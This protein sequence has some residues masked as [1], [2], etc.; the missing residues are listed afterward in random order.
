[1][2][3]NQQETDKNSEVSKLSEQEKA[4]EARKSLRVP[5]S[6]EAYN[7]EYNPATAEK[8][9]TL[10]TRLQT[11]TERVQRNQSAQITLEQIDAIATELNLE[12]RYVR[13]AMLAT[14]AAKTAEQT[15]AK[16]SPVSTQENFAEVVPM[17][18]YVKKITINWWLIAWITLPF[19]ILF[20]YNISNGGYFS[21]ALFIYITQGI[22]FT[23]WSFLEKIATKRKN[24][25]IPTK[26][27]RTAKVSSWQ[28]AKLFTVLWWSIGW[29]IPFI[30]MGLV[31][32]QMTMGHSN[33]SAIV[34]MGQ[35]NNPVPSIIGFSL[36]FIH[37]T[38]GALLT[39]WA[40]NL[41]KK[42]SVK[43]TPPASTPISPVS[44]NNFSRQELL[45]QLFALQKSLEE[46]R[47]QRSFLS[48]DVV[49][50][51]QIKRNNPP[52]A[53]E[54]S[55]GQYQHWIESIVH[56]EDGK[57]QSAAG[58]GV[59]CIFNDDVAAVRAATHLL[60]DIAHFNATQNHCQTPFQIRCGV[61]T[62]EVPAGTEIGKLQSAALDS[63]AILQKNAAPNTLAIASDASEEAL[64]YVGKQ[65]GETDTVIHWSLPV[66]LVLVCLS[67]FAPLKPAQ[68][69]PEYVDR[70]KVSCGY[71]H[72]NPSGGGKRNY[73][74]VYY[75]LNNQSFAQFDDKAE[76]QLSGESVPFTREKPLSLTPPPTLAEA[77]QMADVARKRHAARQMS[78]L[79]GKSVIAR[80]AI[81]KLYLA[82]TLEELMEVKKILGEALV[83]DP[84]SRLA[85][86]YKKRTEDLIFD[87]RMRLLRQPKKQ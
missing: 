80:L 6:A 56:A 16:P 32:A 10:A 35:S 38:L 23:V 83:E 7:Q 69:V 62:G 81:T 77:I 27:P 66:A 22:I 3:L 48:I 51:S 78:D 34:V 5:L 46:S 76:L 71:C 12:P 52:L 15:V 74:G 57:M 21:T 85:R 43:S 86:A 18:H 84:Q 33:N 30:G 17:A 75:G 50:S 8:I 40:K 1:M 2:R 42:A 44:D 59:M 29:V 64:S 20:S 49:G 47:V 36:P 31:S 45:A 28:R 14:R 4:K 26:I 41:R 55:F 58:D 70:E 60:G 82:M 19:S 68:A 11:Q 87:E 9:L 13:E 61:S 72:V 65:H 54:Y 67:I 63:A 73:R 39:N 53:V 25:A 79:V 37:I 24:T